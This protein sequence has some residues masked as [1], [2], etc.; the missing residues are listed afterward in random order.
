MARL[1]AAALAVSLSS[2]SGVA[3]AADRPSSAWNGTEQPRPAPSFDIPNEPDLIGSS[4]NVSRIIAGTEVLP[5][6]TVGFG[7]FGQ[8]VEKSPHASSTVRELAI[9][10]SRRAAV[11]LSFKF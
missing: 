2:V 6:T 7:M 10:K 3:H 1:V 8:K 11:G 5:N 9:P 4:T